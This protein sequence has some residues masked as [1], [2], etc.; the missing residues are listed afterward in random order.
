MRSIQKSFFMILLIVGSVIMIVG[1][2]S[3]SPNQ[4]TDVNDNGDP[5]DDDNS[6][7]DIAK[8]SP[9]ILEGIYTSAL[10]AG[11]IDSSYDAWLNPLEASSGVAIE[12]IVIDELGLLTIHLRNDSDYVVGRVAETSDE[13]FGIVNHAKNAEGDIV[14]T[15]SNDLELNVGN[16]STLTDV[17][18]DEGALILIFDE[19][20]HVN[21]ETLVSESVPN[22]YHLVLFRGFDNGLLD[23]QA[24]PIGESA[25]EPEIVD[26]EGYQFLGW[27]QPF[28]DITSNKTIHTVYEIRTFSVSFDNPYGEPIAPITNVPYGDVVSLPTLVREGYTFT[29]WFLQSD[30]NV[31]FD[32][33]TP[34]TNNVTLVPQFEANTYTITF[35]IDGDNVTQTMRFETDN[36]LTTLMPPTK[37]EH[38][39]AGWYLDAALTQ[40]FTS[41]FMP[42]NDLELYGDWASEGLIYE[43]NGDETFTVSGINQIKTHLRI[44]NRVL[45]DNMF[46]FSGEV[47]TVGNEAFQGLNGIESLYIGRNVTTIDTGAFQNITTLSSVEIAPHSSL[48][49]INVSAFQNTALS[50]FALPDSVLSIGNFAFKDNENL[51]TFT[52]HSSSQLNTFGREVFQGTIVESFY[53]PASLSSM[54]VGL[55]RDVETLQTAL[56]AET[57]ALDNIPNDTFRNTALTHIDIPASIESIGLSAFQMSSLETVVFAENSQLTSLGNSAFASTN[58]THVTLPTTLE[59]IS[60]RAFYNTDLVVLILLSTLDDDLVD[61]DGQFGFYEMFDFTDPDLT[62]YV[63]DETFPI[64]LD[65]PNWVHYASK[66]APLS[67]YDSETE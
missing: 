46:T 35:Y 39:F 52:V 65:E 32:S 16:V 50:N 48:T 62:I 45:G 54:G 18:I 14:F 1:C 61:L 28:N 13:P 8:L 40:P 43:A 34:L 41:G 57:I 11:D 26:V 20:V 21:L 23:I 27:H 60:N 5:L 66:L 37:A 30:T 10:E 19:D 6:Q 58:L 51:S 22:D 7:D 47:V 36:D 2:E 3:D 63:P 44:P 38:V 9:S 24:V 33:T 17:T 4:P 53:F 67:D 12:D 49:T 29:G 25:Q 56:F 59:S 42:P 64:Y 55:F 31:S 15:L